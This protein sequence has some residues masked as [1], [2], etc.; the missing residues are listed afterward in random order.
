MSSLKFKRSVSDDCIYINSEKV[1][2]DGVYVDNLIICVK[3]TNEVV[4]IKTRLA[5]LFPIQDLRLIKKH[6]WFEDNSR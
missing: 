5:S 3:K 1:I 4:E 2:V 6:N